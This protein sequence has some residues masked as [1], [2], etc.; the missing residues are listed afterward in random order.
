MFF[1]R[2][3]QRETKSEPKSIVFQNRTFVMQIEVPNHLTLNHKTVIFFLNL[4]SKIGKRLRNVLELKNF[5][6]Q[7]SPNCE[8]RTNNRGIKSSDLSDSSSGLDGSRTKE[9]F[10]LI[11]IRI[12]LNAFHVLEL[13][14]LVQL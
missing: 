3:R 7:F 5:R 2:R 10:K 8:T 1:F 12:R 11:S 9:S 4:Q 13:S 6:S 14:T